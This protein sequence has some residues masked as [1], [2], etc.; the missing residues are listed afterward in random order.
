MHQEQEDL[1]LE[2]HTHPTLRTVLSRCWLT[3]LLSGWRRRSSAEWPSPLGQA[4][5]GGG[6]GLK[7][8]GQLRTGSKGL[9]SRPASSTL[10]GLAIKKDVG[11]FTYLLPDSCDLY[12][13]TNTILDDKTL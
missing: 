6:P 3:K 9:G 11:H 13:A 5:A 10:A 7:K 8:A 2:F 4:L 12:D 1:F